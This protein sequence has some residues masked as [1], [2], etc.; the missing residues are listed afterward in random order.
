M[1]KDPVCGMVV[2]EKKGEEYSYKIVV[3]PTFMLEF[4]GAWFSYPLKIKSNTNWH[5]YCYLV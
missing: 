3:S 5:G 1:S 2:K 4:T